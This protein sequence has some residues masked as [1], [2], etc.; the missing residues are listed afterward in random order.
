VTQ[1]LQ[2]LNKEG[3]FREK[4]KREEKDLSEMGIIAGGVSYDYHYYGQMVVLV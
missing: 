1:T 4:E 3:L 2:N